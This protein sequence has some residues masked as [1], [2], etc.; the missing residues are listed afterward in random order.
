MVLIWT[1][2]AW[3][4]VSDKNSFLQC[5][6]QKNGLISKPYGFKS[7]A[8][9]FLSTGDGLEQGEEC[10]FFLASLF[11]L[12]MN[13][14]L[15]SMFVWMVRRGYV[16]LILFWRFAFSLWRRFLLLL[17]CFASGASPYVVGR[18]HVLGYSTVHGESKVHFEVNLPRGSERIMGQTIHIFSFIFFM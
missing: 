14:P 5:L 16:L 1:E 17:F 4:K 11:C 10:L 9:S 13:T 12:V 8:V 3:E 2:G 6:K 18:K 15:D 7:T